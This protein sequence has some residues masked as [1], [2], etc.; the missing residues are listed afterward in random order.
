MFVTS[1]SENLKVLEL[2]SFFHNMS[3]CFAFYDVEQ[4]IL[5]KLKQ[6]LHKFWMQF[7]VDLENV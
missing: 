3:Q 4:P 6:K 5:N 7:V 1:F 2:T